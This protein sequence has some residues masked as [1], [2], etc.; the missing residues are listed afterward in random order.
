MRQT[1]TYGGSMNRTYVSRGRIE[2]S[3]ATD[4][5]AE[6]D[7]VEGTLKEQLNWRALFGRF[8][9]KCGWFEAY[10]EPVRFFSVDDARDVRPFIT[11]HTWSLEKLFCRPRNSRYIAIIH[12]SGAVTRAQMKSSIA[13]SAIG[14]FL[15]FFIILSVMVYLEA[16]AAATGFILAIAVL[17]SIP[18]FRSSYRLYKVGKDIIK[19][20]TTSKDEK[21]NEAYATERDLEDVTFSERR[22]VGSD[23]LAGS[24][25]EGL[26]LVSESYRVTS[27]SPRFAWVLFWIEFIFLFLWP[28]VS[29]FSIGNWPLGLLYF[30]IVG[31]SGLRHYVNA[32]IVMEEVGRIDLVDGKSERELWKNQSRLDDIVGNIT[33]G[34]SRRF[35]VL[36]ISVIAFAYLALFAGALGTDQESEE[37]E[38]PSYTYLNDFEYQPVEDSLRYPT[39]HITSDLQESPLTSM[40]DYIFLARVAYRGNITQQELDSWF[41]E[42]VAEDQPSLV[43][44]Y[45][46]ENSVDSQV[47]FKLITYPM[48]ES[49]D[50]VS[51]D[52]AYLAIRGTTNQWEA[53]TDAQLWSPAFMMQ[54]LR[55]LL[56]F[57]SIWAPVMPS[58][59]R[60]LTAI[61]SNSI[62]EISFYKDTVRF[63]EFLQSGDYGGVAV[64]GH[65]LGGGLS[66]MTGAIAHVPSV[67]LSGP[68]TMLT[69]R[70]LDPPVSTE[71]LDRYTFN[72]IPERDIVPMIDDRAQNFQQIR[73]NA[74]YT[75]VIGCHDTTRALCEAIYTCG[76]DGRPPLCECVTLFGFPEPQPIDPNSGITFAEACNITVSL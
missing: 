22:R 13:C 52:F 1:A 76:S 47:S 61:E 12:G 18:N 71:E 33:R 25:S 69:R 6:G 73:C 26:Y 3:E 23:R 41:G 51:R 57:G 72:I 37:I 27:P 10:E 32:A 74:D 16:G 70:S 15:V 43:S 31:V 7:L 19:G 48:R 54:F 29:L 4:K 68:N 17:L 9:Q 38:D 63:A 28:T 65:S 67:A 49:T 64:T 14:S 35:W 20:R 50:G 30:L 60:A 11:S 2:N 75:D 46:E 53:L 34:R 58:F 66:M 8:F 42:G 56:P 62:E 39:C 59:I 44:S 36:L 55:E 45:R 5:N 40:A 24:D 21:Q